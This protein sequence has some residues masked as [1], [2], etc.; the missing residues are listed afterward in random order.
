MV[1]AELLLPQANIE[2][3]VAK[4]F[5]Y[6]TITYADQLRLKYALLDEDGLTEQDLILI[7]RILYG[8][9]HG[10]LKVID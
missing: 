4:V 9:R 1:S 5:M 2:E 7:N 6:R 8:V 10:L 3:L